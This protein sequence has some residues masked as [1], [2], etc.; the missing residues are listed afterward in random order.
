MKAFISY[1]RNDAFMGTES[2]GR[3]DFA[4]IDKLASALTL[5]G[6]TEVFVDKTAVRTGD[7][8]ESRIHQAITDC[9]LLVAVIGRS[10][11]AIMR[12]KIAARERD[13]LVREIRAAL[14]QEKEIA[15]LLVDGAVMPRPTDLPEQIRPLQEISGVAISS[16]A[17]VEDIAAKLTHS[18]RQAA[19]IRRLGSRW[20]R[21][22]VI[23]AGFAYYCCALQPHLVG[24]WEFGSQPWGGMVKVWSGFYI[25]PIF[26]LPFALVS[27]YRPLTVL[28]ESAANASRLKDRLTYLTPLIL[29]TL[30]SLLAI[31]IEV[32]GSF[33]VPWSIHPA[34]P[35]CSHSSTT[36]SSDWA[37]LSSYDRAPTPGEAGP[38]FERYGNEFWLKDKCWPNVFYYLTVPVYQNSTNPGYLAERPGV[39]RAFMSMLST[40]S[41]APYSA[42]F[43]PYV[44]S[45]AILAWLGCTGVIMSVFYVTVQIRRPGDDAVLRLPSEDAYLCLTYSF[46]TLMVWLPFRMNTIY[47]KNLYACETLENCVI[48]PQLYLNDG[49]LGTMLLIGYAFLTVGLLVKYRRLVLGLLGA[50]AV[51]TILFAS[52]AVFRFSADIAPLTELW[53][54]Y[55]GVSIPSI[56]IMLALWYQFDP[57]VVHF[58]DFKKDIE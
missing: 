10:W 37:I 40:E 23:F 36:A 29:G 54:F 18:S 47:F 15:P 21:A 4:F 17:S 7:H 43:F 20:L 52:F 9:D 32:G 25:W 34:L 28:I 30:I 39:Q 2:G 49:V 14:K 31:A 46:V 5:A 53:Q 45:F 11:L 44:L 16:N 24:V 42:S 3:P 26:F 1:R 19:D 27:L 8:F 12:D 50:F 22:Y 38:L 58:N 13:I 55:V 41:G 6:F 35:G 33:E 56:V 48:N 57:S 51:A